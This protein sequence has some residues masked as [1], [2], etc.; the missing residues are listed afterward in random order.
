MAGLDDA[1]Q[2][3]ERGEQHI[4]EYFDYMVPLMN[5]EKI[6]FE[7][8]KQPYEKP[9]TDPRLHWKSYTLYISHVPIIP[10]FAGI[11]LGEAIQSFRC[12]L[13]YLT[14]SLVQRHT[15]SRIS[16]RKKKDIQFPMYRSRNGFYNDIKRRLPNVPPA[17]CTFFERY[18]PYRRS[19]AGRSIRYLQ[20]LSNTDKHR[21]IVPAVLFPLESEG[22]VEPQKT[23]LVSADLHLKKGVEI[24]RG[25]KVLTVIVAGDDPNPKVVFTTKL[26]FVPMFPKT[27]V[28]AYGLNPAIH[29]EPA[30]KDIRE[31]CKEILTEAK[32]FF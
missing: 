10:R 11:L 25:M 22:K 4:V 20:A 30:L 8:Q 7:I 24:R 29:I 23:N 6:S 17:E 26:S 5:K 21:I 3:F 14:W 28:R 2:R 12:S 9:A 16:E 19:P 18:Q 32:K 27:V 1:F 31:T 15:R 13:D